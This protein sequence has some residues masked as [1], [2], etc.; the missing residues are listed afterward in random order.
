[1]CLFS[2]IRRG[3]FFSIS[4]PSLDTA[5]PLTIRFCL[6]LTYRRSVCKLELLPSHAGSTPV[7]MLLT[8]DQKFLVS[9][10][11]FAL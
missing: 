10:S 2:E 7:R 6:S 3:P 4:F 9:P 1:M 8:H 11:P 5:Q